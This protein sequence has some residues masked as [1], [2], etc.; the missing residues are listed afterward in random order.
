[1]RDWSELTKYVEV[2]QLTSEYAS[3]SSAINPWMVD[4]KV[5]FADCRKMRTVNEAMMHA[6]RKTDSLL[7]SDDSSSGSWDGNAI[8]AEAAR[9][10]V[11]GRNNDV[12]SEAGIS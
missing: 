4:I 9:D 7:A 5:K 11:R 10:T 2:N 12:L 8:D 1:M 3:R 6:P